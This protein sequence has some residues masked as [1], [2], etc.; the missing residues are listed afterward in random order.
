MFDLVDNVRWLLDK[1]FQHFVWG[2]LCPLS[3]IVLLFHG[4]SGPVSR[5]AELKVVQRGHF[6]FEG[7]RCRVFETVEMFSDS[8]YSV[9]QRFS[10]CN[11]PIV[12]MVPGS[13][14]AGTTKEVNAP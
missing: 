9:L 10:V 13:K 11:P 8:N 2:V 12:G 5:D 4:C 6:D 1:A 7:S 3:L 14:P